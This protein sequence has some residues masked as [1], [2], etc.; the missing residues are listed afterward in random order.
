MVDTMPIPPNIREKDVPP[1][2][3]LN[4]TS[5]VPSDRYTVMLVFV[6][7]RLSRGSV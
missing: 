7:L 4:A 5:V 2:S 6:G 1:K 3:S